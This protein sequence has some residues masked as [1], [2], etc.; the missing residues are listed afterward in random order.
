MDIWDVLESYRPAPVCKD[1][2]RISIWELQR[3][4]EKEAKKNTCQIRFQNQ[5]NTIA[6]NKEKNITAGSLLEKVRKYGIKN[7]T[8]RRKQRTNLSRYSITA[9][10]TAVRYSVPYA[11]KTNIE[12]AKVNKPRLGPLFS[13]ISTYSHTSAPIS[14]PPTNIFNH[15][16]MTNTT[17][18]KN[19]KMFYDIGEPKLFQ[20]PLELEEEVKCEKP[21]I[22][23]TKLPKCRADYGAVARNTVR[24]LQNM[25]WSPVVEIEYMGYVGKRA[26]EISRKKGVVEGAKYVGSELVKNVVQIPEFCSKHTPTCLF[27]SVTKLPIPIKVEKISIEAPKLA[28][29]VVIH[30]GER[31]IIVGRTLNKAVIGD[32]GIINDVY[33]DVGG[34]IIVGKVSKF[35]PIKLYNV[36]TKNKISG[37]TK[38]RKIVQFDIVRDKRG[39]GLVSVNIDDKLNI[40]TSR[41][42][43]IRKIS[44]KTHYIESESKKTVT[45]TITVRHDK[46]GK[47]LYCGLDVK[48]AVKHLEKTETHKYDFDLFNLHLIDTEIKIKNTAIPLLFTGIK[49]N[50]L[51]YKQRVIKKQMIKKQ[52][53]NK[54]QNDWFD[55]DIF[56]EPFISEIIKQKHDLTSKKPQYKSSFLNGHMKLEEKT[57]MKEKVKKKRK[58]KEKEGKM[59]QAH[60]NLSKQSVLKGYA[61]SLLGIEYNIH[62][63]EDKFANILPIRP[64]VKK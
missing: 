20:F 63:K 35:G 27:Q 30:N 29:H 36:L 3:K 33:S 21:T 28:E 42:K 2:K 39:T 51:S 19:I 6:K 34:D 23:S 59:T 47:A 49:V 54:K 45:R 22:G 55:I 26:V 11:S 38:T 7:G 62:I 10:P 64:L 17:V 48:E 31:G 24:E 8:R 9:S 46:R 41:V 18:N 60:I 58:K 14:Q 61:P 37:K 40:Y 44:E 57:E 50:K 16:L 13:S 12:N 43:E 56:D 52:N 5:K 53:A 1:P 15:L 25:F 32:I 4:I